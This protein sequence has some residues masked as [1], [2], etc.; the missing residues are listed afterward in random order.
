M[1]N[2]KKQA[3]GWKTTSDITCKCN[4]RVF[5]TTVFVRNKENKEKERK[6]KSTQKS[7]EERGGGEGRTRVLG[8]PSSGT[9]RVA[10]LP[11]YPP[12]CQPCF[13]EFSP[14]FVSPSENCITSS[15]RADRARLA[16]WYALKIKNEAAPTPSSH[17]ARD[18]NCWRPISHYL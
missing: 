7:D 3:S 11:C 13:P 2:V 6:H 10:V 8:G 1:F 4:I 17:G 18:P 16:L 14:L 12:L 9:I 5:L 15:H